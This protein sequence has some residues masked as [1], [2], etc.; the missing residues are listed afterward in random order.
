MNTQDDNP[1]AK[2][3]GV[4]LLAAKAL[5]NKFRQRSAFELDHS[6]RCDRL[7]AI[8]SA[9]RD[10]DLLPKEISAEL[11]WRY[12]EASLAV[13]VLPSASETELA[14]KVAAIGPMSREFLP[15]RDAA[16]LANAL[17]AAM[18]SDGQFLGVR[19]RT[20]VDELSDPGTGSLN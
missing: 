5:L 11:G 14:K 20:N 17:I 16:L 18:I 15:S 19:V 6:A 1:S 10:R 4:N 2:A 9:L 7:N 12:I 3:A 13:A 8:R